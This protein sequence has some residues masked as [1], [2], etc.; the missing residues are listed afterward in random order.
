[1]NEIDK[2]RSALWKIDH[3][4]CMN[5][6]EHNI[7]WNIDSPEDYPEGGYDPYDTD[8]ND[9]EDFCNCYDLLNEALN[10]LEKL[11]KEKGE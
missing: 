6:N 5:F 3:T 1:M 8:C 10:K 9:F 2:Y 7:K 11:L 4:I